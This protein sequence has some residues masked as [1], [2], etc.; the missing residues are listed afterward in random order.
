MSILFGSS[1]LHATPVDL[2]CLS[3]TAARPALGSKKPQ[4]SPVRCNGKH[5][6]RPLTHI[7]NWENTSLGTLTHESTSREKPTGNHAVA[8][9]RPQKSDDLYNFQ[10]R[11]TFTPP[12][13]ASANRTG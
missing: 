7:D 3:F 4:S 8:G 9:T 2:L 12:T 11:T 10:N 5:F 1:F 6:P 13:T